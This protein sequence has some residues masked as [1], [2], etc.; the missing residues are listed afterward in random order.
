MAS[1]KISDCILILQESWEYS[2]KKFEELYPDDPQPMLTCTHRSNEEQ[3][4]LYAIGRSVKGSI[5]TRAKAGES[6]HNVKPS[7]AFDIAFIGV[8]KKLHWNL[9]YFERFAKII[10]E[11]FPSIEWG[12]DWKKFKDRPHFQLK[13]WKN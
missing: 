11:K 1:R 9:E 2:E 13:N 7:K 5:I 6:P 4:Q 8:D 12:G 3:T 10:K